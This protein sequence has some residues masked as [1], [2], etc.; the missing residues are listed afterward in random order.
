MAQSNLMNCATKGDAVSMALVG[1]TL[2]KDV[3]RL[4][5]ALGEAEVEYQQS[6]KRIGVKGNELKLIDDQINDLKVACPVSDGP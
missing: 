2:D 3:D 4:A 5:E 6:S 1:V